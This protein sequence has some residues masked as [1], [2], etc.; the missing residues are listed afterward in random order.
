MSPLQYRKQLRL[1]RTRERMIMDGVDATSAAYE[2]G[3]RAS[4]NSI[5]NTAASLALTARS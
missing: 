1:Q 4:A 2:V 3:T 5:E